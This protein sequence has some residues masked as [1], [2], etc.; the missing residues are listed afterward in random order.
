MQ[1]LFFPFIFGP[2]ICTN[3]SAFDVHFVMMQY[4]LDIIQYFH[5]LSFHLTEKNGARSSSL[6]AEIVFLYYSREYVSVRY[7]TI[8]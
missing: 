8:A 4:P 2:M 3:S 7:A 5:H 6:A 1:T